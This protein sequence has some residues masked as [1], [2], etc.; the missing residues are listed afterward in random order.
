M[1]CTG[2]NSRASS[3]PDLTGRMS[4]SNKVSADGRENDTCAVATVA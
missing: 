3:Q 2:R 1:P 4:N